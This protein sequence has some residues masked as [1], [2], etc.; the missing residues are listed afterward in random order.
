MKWKNVIGLVMFVLV[1][2]GMGIQKQSLAGPVI[3]PV[4]GDGGGGGGGGSFF[5]DASAQSGHGDVRGW[6]SV[7]GTGLLVNEMSGS[8]QI[9]PDNNPDDNIIARFSANI[10]MSGNF[11][12]GPNDFPKDNQGPS[13]NGGASIYEYSLVHSENGDFIEGVPNFSLWYSGNTNYYTSNREGPNGEIQLPELWTN[14]YS[15]FYLTGQNN[16]QITNSWSD[17]SQNVW[18]GEGPKPD[19]FDLSGWNGNMGVSG[20]ITPEPAS[21]ALLGLGASSLLLRRKKSRERNPIA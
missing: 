2:S 1:L 10:D 13:V 4:G 12:H 15:N 20:V 11:V 8:A 21:L 9:Y 16:A 6:A 7:N 17:F 19:W 18:S 5:P 3:V 14:I